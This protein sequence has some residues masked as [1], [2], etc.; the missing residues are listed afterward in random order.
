MGP[1]CKFC[2][3]RCFV[4]M[5]DEAPPEAIKAYGTCGIIATCGKGQAFEL[6]KV[7]W[8]YDKIRIFIEIRKLP[9]RAA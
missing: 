7:G 1:Y 2:N 4:H 8:N 6:G 5:P 3:S 9:E